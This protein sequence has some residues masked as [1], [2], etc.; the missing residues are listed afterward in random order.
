MSILVDQNTKV[1]AQC[2]TGAARDRAAGVR[3]DRFLARSY[4]THI[5]CDCGV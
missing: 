5:L 4:F 3:V 1:I 2:M